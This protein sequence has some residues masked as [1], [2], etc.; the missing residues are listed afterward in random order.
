MTTRLPPRGFTLVEVLLVILLIGMLAVSV[1]ISFSGDSRDQRLSK[2]TEQLQQLIQL[3]SETA[4]L[5][6]QE[7]GLFINAEGYRFMLFKDDKW[8]SIS[9]PKALRPRQ[10]PAGFAVELELEGLEWSEGNLL[11]Q[12]EWQDEEEDALFEE[13]SF[14]EL[15]QKKQQEK[16]QQQ[17]EKTGQPQLSTGFE[18]LPRQKRDPRLPQVFILSSGEI[19]PFLLSI[20]EQSDKPVWRQE[21]KAVFSIPL[22]RSEVSRER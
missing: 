12:V 21:L 9:Q 16:Q 10:F 2:E 8:H 20:S 14:D 17:A 18:T 7:L 3:A 5:K 13:N 6:Q 22:E 15:A 11:S 19:T 4:M 1:V